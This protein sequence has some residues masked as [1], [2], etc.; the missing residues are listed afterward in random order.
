MSFQ[1]SPREVDEMDVHA[2][3]DLVAY[4]NRHAPVHLMLEAFLE[5]RMKGGGKKGGDGGSSGGGGG[6]EVVQ[7]TDL[8]TAKR[9]VAML[10]GG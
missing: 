5:V 2:L 9:F 3:E 10:N 7:V 6:D 8:E 1:L 4:T